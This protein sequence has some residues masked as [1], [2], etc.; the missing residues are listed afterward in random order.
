MSV[1]KK[2]IKVEEIKAYIEYPC[3]SPTEL[4]YFTCH[5]NSFNFSDKR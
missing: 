2:V 4:R 1:N 3:H 5:I